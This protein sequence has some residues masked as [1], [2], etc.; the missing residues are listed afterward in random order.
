MHLCEHEADLHLQRDDAWLWQGAPRGARARSITEYIDQNAIEIRRRYLAWSW[1]FGEIEVGGRKL[2]ERFRLPDGTSFWW[3]A[4]FAEQSTW[5]QHSLEPL[6]KICA[7]EL[8]LER[9][10][11]LSL[12]F[13][14]SDRRLDQA[15]KAVCR[16]Q[17]VRYSWI[18][19][20]RKLARTGRGLLRALPKP[21]QALLAIGYFVRVRL[22]L[23]P[24]RAQSGT[25]QGRRVLFCGAFANHNARP[26]AV[27]PFRSQFWGTLPQALVQDGYVVSWLHYFHATAQVPD[28][29][30]G[31]AVLRRLNEGAVREQRHLC[32][33]SYLHPVSLARILHRWISIACESV[34]T[35][36]RLGRLFATGRARSHWPLIREDWARAFRGFPAVESLVYLECFDRAL[37]RLERQDEGLYLMENQGWERCLARAWHR[38]GHGRLSG[39]AHSTVRFWDLRYHSDPRRYASGER[40]RPPLPDYVCVNGPVARE[41]YLASCPEREPVV[42]CEALRYLHL[43]PGVPRPLEL[44]HAEGLRLLVLGDYTRKRT[45]ALLAAATQTAGS[46]HVPIELW[47]KPHPGCPLDPDEAEHASLRI[48]HDPVATLVAAA[49]LVMASNTTSAAL[50]AYVSGARVLVFDDGSG[51]NYSPLRGMDGV[52]FVRDA[53][54][55]RRAIA[56]LDPDARVDSRHT[57]RFFNIDPELRAWRRYLAPATEGTSR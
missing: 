45:R 16:R 34:I 27:G 20:R 50:E 32:V 4:L 18:R 7:I 35:G 24:P 54:D 43:S 42:D 52:T 55:V 57:E 51:V 17:D 49:H 23:G 29:R 15:L 41:Q 14:G 30:A 28:A 21:A 37:A 3:Y 47:V 36:Y 13:C 38:Y 46:S 22:A 53:D 5:K 11:P 26:D 9:E 56:A 31:A 6:L 8:L 2:R 40:D 39:V 1:E 33:E 48:V 12:E 25:S 44:G 19:T 10:R